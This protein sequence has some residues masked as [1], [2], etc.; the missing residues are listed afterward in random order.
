MSVDQVVNLSDRDTKRRLMTHIGA[1][2][3]P[4]SVTLKRWRPRRSTRANAYYWAVVVEQLR[5][6][7][8]QHGSNYTKEQAHDLLASDLLP[9]DM[10]HPETG[11]LLGTTRQSTATLNNEEFAAYIDRCIE[12]LG[13]WGIE[14][15]MPYTQEYA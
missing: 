4:H 2:Q 5:T 15:P 9:V 10:I 13:R 6:F 3:G 11:E 7:L 14:V 12:R 8:N 1:L